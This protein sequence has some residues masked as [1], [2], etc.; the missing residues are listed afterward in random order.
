MCLNWASFEVAECKLCVIFMG[1]LKMEM[2]GMLFTV[3]DMWWLFDL[4]KIDLYFIDS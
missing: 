4:Y 3:I 2:L 1:G